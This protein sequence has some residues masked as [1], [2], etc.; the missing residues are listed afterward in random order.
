MKPN[1]SIHKP[2]AARLHMHR[3]GSARQSPGYHRNQGRLGIASY[4]MQ[5]KCWQ[6]VTGKGQLLAIDVALFRRRTAAA[7]QVIALAAEWLI[8]S[9]PGQRPLVASWTERRLRPVV[10]SGP[11][12]T[13]QNRIKPDQTGR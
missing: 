3:R 13:G 9:A 10:A 12:V 11:A 2:R 8:F 1:S 5:R 7:R 4:H 6:P